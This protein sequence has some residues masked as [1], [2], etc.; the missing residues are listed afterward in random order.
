MQRASFTGGTFAATPPQPQPDRLTVAYPSGRT[1]DVIGIFFLSSPI[2][3]WLLPTIWQSETAVTILDAR[4][5]V[6]IGGR[7]IYS[8]R[9][10]PRMPPDLAEWMQENPQWAREPLCASN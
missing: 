4:A 1:F 10:N 6:T 2:R 8:P 7:E 3:D 5:V 9:D